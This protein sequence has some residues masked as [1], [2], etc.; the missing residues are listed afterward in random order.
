MDAYELEFD[1]KTEWPNL[2]GSRFETCTFRNV[3]WS[4]FDLRGARFED[5]DF[6][7]CDLS[8]AK[9][10]GLGF[11]EVR[12]ERSKLLGFKFDMCNPLGLSFQLIECNLTAASFH[13]LDLRNV[14]LEKCNAQDVDFTGAWAEGLHFMEVDLNGALFERTNLKGADFTSAKNWRI[15]PNA[16]TMQKAKFCKD[17]LSGLLETWSLNIQ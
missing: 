6:Q 8:N 3:N 5:C 9:T 15:D 2:K 13:A 17:E 16:N 10:L 1:G 12:F 4:G 14:T 11:Q 7:D